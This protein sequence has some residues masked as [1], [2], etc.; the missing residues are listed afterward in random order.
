VLG[1]P[2]RLA[3]L[4][5]LA[6]GSANVAQLV[7]AVGSPSRSRVGNHLACLA[8]CGLVAA[9]RVGRTV[10]YTLADPAVLGLLDLADEVAAPH[11]PHLAACTRIGPDWV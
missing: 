4:R 8:W 5:R 11:A 10:V 3:L 7:E 6:Q 1:D 9:E 2:T